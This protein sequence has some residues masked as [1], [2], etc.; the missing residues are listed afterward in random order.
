V[1]AGDALAQLMELSTEI[2]EVATA[3]ADGALEAFTGCS[4]DRADELIRAG[5]DLV[6]LAPTGPAVSRIQ[7]ERA[8]GGL[9]VVV[10]AGRMAVATTVADA[11]AGLV[12][13]DLRAALRRSAPEA[14][15]A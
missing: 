6:A 3:D 9:H 8:G 10:E 7:V 4:P 11:T 5:L 1:D 12:T 13:H 2:V 15:D 14:V